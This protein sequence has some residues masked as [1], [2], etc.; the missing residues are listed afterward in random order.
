MRHR[1]YEV[2]NLSKALSIL[3]R[4]YLSQKETAETLNNMVENICRVFLKNNAVIKDNVGELTEV[5]ESLREFMNVFTP[6]VDELSR[7]SSDILNLSREI[8]KINNNLSEIEKI[9]SDTELI[10]INAAIEA[11]RAGEAG[12][13][14]AVV[15]NEIK[16]MSK[17]TFRILWEIEKLSKEIDKKVSVLRKTVETVSEL[18]KASE[19]LLEGMDKLVRISRTLSEIYSEQE[20]VSN[21]VKGLSGISESI[22]KIFQLLSE[23]KSKVAKSL[24][25]CFSS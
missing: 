18:Q 11:A 20:K 3:E 12:R 17:E 16:E 23:A 19:E 6:I 9:A 14:F 8:E 1:P 13:G 2:D 10:A 21:S 7:N 15:A 4:C 5:S 25:S 24:T 22:N